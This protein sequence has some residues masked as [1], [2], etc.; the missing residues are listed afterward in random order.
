MK[1]DAARED[2]GDPHA[3][4][5]VREDGDAERVVLGVL[6]VP[7]GW[8]GSAERAVREK[9]TLRVRDAFAGFAL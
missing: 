2:L 8:T 7:R 1:S 4:V 6:E 5:C 9:D 3:A